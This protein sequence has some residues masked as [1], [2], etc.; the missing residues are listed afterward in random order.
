MDNQM[1]NYTPM[2]GKCIISNNKPSGTPI[3]QATQRLETIT[4]QITI[5]LDSLCRRLEPY[6]S[7]A[8][9]TKPSN[10]TAPYSGSSSYTMQLTGLCSRLHSIDQV[11]CSIMER[12]EV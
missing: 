8:P 5:D 6:L 3:E 4:E 11:L 9:E 10:P 12:L 1:P 7:K 2:P